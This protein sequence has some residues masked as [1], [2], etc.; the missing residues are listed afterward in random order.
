[1]GE[2][3]FEAL[4]GANERIQ[5]TDPRDRGSPT[6]T[7]GE[8]VGFFR[9]ARTVRVKYAMLV[10]AIPHHESMEDRAAG[11]HEEAPAMADTLH[12]NSK[13]TDVGRDSRH[14]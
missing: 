7:G 6:A 14:A 2:A 5:R 4:C 10:R 1:M 13:H 3:G 12:D 8:L 9:T 11:H